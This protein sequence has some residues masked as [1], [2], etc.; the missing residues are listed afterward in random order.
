MTFWN[1]EVFGIKYLYL[2]LLGVGIIAFIA[3]RIKPVSGDSSEPTAATDENATSEVGGDLGADY[4][5]LATTGTVTVQQ[6]GEP[7]IVTP[8]TPQTNEKWVRDGVNWLVSKGLA[9]GGNAQTAL[10]KYVDGDQLSFDEGKL[11]DAWIAQGGAP[12]ETF[13]NGG[14]AA[15]PPTAPKRNGTPPTTHTVSGTADNTIDKISQLYYGASDNNHTGYVRIHNPQWIGA[16]IPVG[17]KVFVPAYVKKTYITP[18]PMTSKEVA[19]AAKVN[20]NMV[21][22]LNKATPAYVFP[23]KTAVLIP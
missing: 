13:S 20:G 23:A 15:A 7:T 14:T 11:R 2:A 5:A 22:E 21:L 19:A 16:T 18:R 1:K 17:E 8:V 4:S 9:T 10:Q 6:A 12:P 3:W